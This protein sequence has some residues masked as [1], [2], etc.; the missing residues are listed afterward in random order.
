M[1]NLQSL[2]A[3]SAQEIYRSDR[4]NQ[5]SISQHRGMVRIYVARVK[6]SRKTALLRR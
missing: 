4:Q 6:I 2:Q 1:G 5:C 3:T